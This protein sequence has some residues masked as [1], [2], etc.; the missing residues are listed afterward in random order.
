[1]R[2]HDRAPWARKREEQVERVRSIKRIVETFEA[3]GLSYRRLVDMIDDVINGQP[4]RI[5]RVGN[6][7]TPEVQT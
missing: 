3:G 7:H 4:E 6:T 1:M 5:V 2:W